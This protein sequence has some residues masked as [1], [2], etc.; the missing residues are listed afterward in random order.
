[1]ISMSSRTFAFFATL[2]LAIAQTNSRETAGAER[3]G[4][5]EMR[6]HFKNLQGGPWTYIQTSRA[7][8]SVGSLWTSPSSDELPDTPHLP[9]SECFA[10]EDLK[11]SIEPEPTSYLDLKISKAVDLGW[12]AGLK[13]LGIPIVGKDSLIEIEKANLRTIVFSYKDVT[14]VGVPYEGKFKTLLDRIRPECKAALLRSTPKTYVVQKMILAKK[15]TV[16]L[17]DK[18]GKPIKLEGGLAKLFAHFSRTGK[19]DNTLE[20]EGSTTGCGPRDGFVIAVRYRPIELETN[21]STGST[22]RLMEPDLDA[23]YRRLPLVR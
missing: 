19:D 1:M 10:E 7:G 15:I 23:I 8:L 2:T 21:Q 22:I 11:A 13:L 12:K 9:P 17:E 4:H 6:E 3:A 16:K 14:E 20:Y 18:A 5:S